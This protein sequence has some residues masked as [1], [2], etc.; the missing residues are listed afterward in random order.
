[1]PLPPFVYPPWLEPIP[2]P[3]TAPLPPAV[4]LPPPVRVPEA[5]PPPPPSVIQPFD[6]LPSVPGPMA[7]PAPNLLPE[8]PDNAQPPVGGLR[9]GLSEYDRRL[10]LGATGAIVSLARSV[11]MGHI[12]TGSASLEIIADHTGSIRSVR[13]VDVDGERARW[14]D[15]AEA[16]RGARAPSMRVSEVTRGVWMRLWVSANIERASG[17]RNWWSQGVFLTFDLADTSAHR[18]RLV[19]TRVLSQVWF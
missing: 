12:A 14:E 15:Y 18:Q 19:E 10:G 17:R 3:F 16:L 11:A 5:V 13:V 1:V 7:P 4:P 6:L 2:P 9:Q 8:R